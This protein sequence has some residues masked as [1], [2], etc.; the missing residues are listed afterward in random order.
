MRVIQLF[1]KVCVV[2]HRGSTVTIKWGESFEDQMLIT[3]PRL[4][5]FIDALLSEACA[6]R[7]EVALKRR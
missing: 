5:E 4:Y 7:D 6:G 3:E 1:G 2:N